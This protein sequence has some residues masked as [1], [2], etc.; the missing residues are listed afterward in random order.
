LGEMANV[1]MAR[2]EW[3]AA[4]AALTEALALARRLKDQSGIAFT[5][6]KLGQVA[7]ARGD[8]AT[9]LTRYREGLA[10][11][12]RLGMARGAQQV[13]EMIADLESGEL[14]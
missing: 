11:F 14:V 1:H 13:R 8:G 3:D 7:R 5:T 12:E 9:A 4:E 6:V 10:I 2:Q